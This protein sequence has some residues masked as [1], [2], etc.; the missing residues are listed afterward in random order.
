MSVRS[1]KMID[2]LL[3]LGEKLT[4]GKVEL[5]L[6][7]FTAIL[8]SFG[9]GNAFAAL[10]GAVTVPPLRRAL[11]HIFWRFCVALLETVDFGHGAICE[12]RRR[13]GLTNILLHLTFLSGVVTVIFDILAT[14]YSDFMVLDRLFEHALR[15]V[16]WCVARLQ[17]LDRLLVRNLMKLILIL[18]FLASRYPP[19]RVLVFHFFLYA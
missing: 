5:L 8:G 9:R 3:C 10:G 18:F 13:I 12:E 15:P 6:V 1:H 11:I 2:L 7:A 17:A 4:F 14:I 16:S 19:L